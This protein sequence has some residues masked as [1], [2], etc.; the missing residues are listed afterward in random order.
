MI[1]AKS[2]SDIDTDTDTYAHNFG[3][4]IGETD[5]FCDISQSV[6]NL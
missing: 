6:A 1:P 4:N 3:K 5:I 2:I